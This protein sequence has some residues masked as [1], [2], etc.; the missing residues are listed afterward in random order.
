MHELIANISQKILL[1][2][3]EAYYYSFFLASLVILIGSKW[4]IGSIQSRQRLSLANPN[5]NGN[6]YSN[7]WLHNQRGT[8]KV[9][10]AL[11]ANI[12]PWSSVLFWLASEKDKQDSNQPVVYWTICFSVQAFLSLFSRRW[13]YPCFFCFLFCACICVYLYW[14]F[15]IRRTQ[16]FYRAMPF[17]SSYFKLIEYNPSIP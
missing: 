4:F 12:P 8:V 10:G 15:M 5:R 11:R 13:P 1:I 9:Y 6:I 7:C 14:V 2:H 17:A 3:Y 16:L